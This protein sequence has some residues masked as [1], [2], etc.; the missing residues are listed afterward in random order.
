MY[1]YHTTQK[2]LK[3]YRQKKRNSNLYHLLEWI[4]KSAPTNLANISLDSEIKIDYL[5]KQNMIGKSIP[6]R[7]Y[8]ENILLDSHLR[9]YTIII[10]WK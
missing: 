2:H 10:H 7:F 8:S 5:Y 1:Q 6:F 9:N 3:N 4:I